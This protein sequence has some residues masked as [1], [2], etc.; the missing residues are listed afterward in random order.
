MGQYKPDQD[1]T[2]GAK[3]LH[4]NEHGPFKYTHEYPDGDYPAPTEVTL[5]K[6]EDFSTG[7]LSSKSAWISLPYGNENNATIIEA[8]GNRFLRHCG[9]AEMPL[10]DPITGKASISKGK[11]LILP[12]T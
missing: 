1:F 8:G 12:R 10:P 6:R 11:P 7:T 2:K 9:V 5:L 3:K 4:P